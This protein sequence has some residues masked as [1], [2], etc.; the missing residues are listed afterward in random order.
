MNTAHTATPWAIRDMHIV[1]ESDKYR[2]VATVANPTKELRTESIANAEFIVRACNSHD[3]LV[4][5]LQTPPEHVLHYASMP[6]AHSSANK[7]VATA[8]AAL[9]AAGAK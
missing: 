2:V 8:R 9:A 1:L 5:A 4:A 3:A 6:H 7:D